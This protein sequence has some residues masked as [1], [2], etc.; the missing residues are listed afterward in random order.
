ME[1]KQIVDQ[2]NISDMHDIFKERYFLPLDL[3]ILIFK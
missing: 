3:P 2:N 1:N